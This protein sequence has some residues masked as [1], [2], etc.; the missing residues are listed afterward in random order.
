MLVLVFVNNHPKEFV[1]PLNKLANRYL[2]I[3]FLFIK[4]I[5]LSQVATGHAGLGLTS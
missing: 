3:D 4:K 1:S 5:S 2:K